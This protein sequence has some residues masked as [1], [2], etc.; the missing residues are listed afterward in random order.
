MTAMAAVIASP[1]SRSLYWS[2]DRNNAG[3]LNGSALLQSRPLR[4]AWIEINGDY[5]TLN[6]NTVAPLAGRVDRN[7]G[8]MYSL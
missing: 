2:V 3:D 6:G 5:V 7:M 1:T 4:G 8:Q